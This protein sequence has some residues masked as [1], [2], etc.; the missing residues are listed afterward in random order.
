MSADIYDAVIEAVPRSSWMLYTHDA[1]LV[2]QAENYTFEC[3]RVVD[4]LSDHKYAPA[5]IAGR[6]LLATAKRYGTLI[7]RG[8]KR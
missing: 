4:S 1:P 7:V 3:N 5:I 2:M 6:R 8:G